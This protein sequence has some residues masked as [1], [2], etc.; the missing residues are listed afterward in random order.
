MYN[1][2]LPRRQDLPSSAQ[3]L[4][5][6]IIALAVAIAL[7]VAVILPAEYG[8][9]PTG[10]G[11]MLGLTQMGEI[12]AQLAEEAARDEARHADTADL[13]MPPI[14]ET[15]FTEIAVT[16][17]QP[18]SAAQE[19]AAADTVEPEATAAWTDEVR[20]TL[21]PGEAAEIKLVMTQ[22]AVVEYNWLVSDGH[23]NFDLHGNGVG[24]QSISYEKGR[25]QTGKAGALQAA[26][27]GAHGWFWRNRSDVETELRIRVRGQYD[28]MKRV[29]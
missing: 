9:D 26:F 7:L 29:L 6:T 18:E 16:P 24:G 23:L 14:T 10:V 1:T 22:D 15:E 8:V 5:S 2:D 17:Q 4:R 12:K 3:L 27:D 11:R 20:L 28:E 21:A 25:A 19:P 13:V